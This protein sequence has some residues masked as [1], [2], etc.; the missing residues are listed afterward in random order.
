MLQI[1]EGK[2][3]VDGH[4]NL[5]GPMS[6]N[7]EGLCRGDIEG[8]IGILMGGGFTFRYESNGVWCR[9]DP[10]TRKKNDL[11]REINADGSEIHPASVHV[12]AAVSRAAFW[13]PDSLTEYSITPAFV[14][15]APACDC[16]S[17]YNSGFHSSYCSTQGGS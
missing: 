4:G 1:E 16:G 5:V 3:Y 12:L 10:S 11:V 14:Q 9:G 7:G 17:K 13:D 8:P 6:V 15:K 2:Y